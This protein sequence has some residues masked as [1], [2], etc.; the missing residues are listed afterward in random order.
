MLIYIGLRP[1]ISIHA[2]L[3]RCDDFVLSSKAPYSYFNPRTSFEV[4]LFHVNLLSAGVVF[5]STHLFRGATSLMRMVSWLK[6]F[7][8]THFFRRATSLMRMVSWL[9]PF[10]STH[11][12]RGA[13]LRVPQARWLHTDFN[14]RTSFEVRLKSPATTALSLSFQ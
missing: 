12:F 1:S 8:S 3:S 10:Q 2:P 4:R 5:Q 6:Q 14:P 7:Q 11:L 9:K 13:T